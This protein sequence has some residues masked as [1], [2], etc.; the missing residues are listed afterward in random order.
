[1][2]TEI[3]F[4][5]EGRK[6][7]LKGINAI[8]DAVKVTLGAKGRNVIISK[9]YETLRITKD[10]VTVAKS[11]ELEDL[12]ENIGATLIKEVAGKTVDISGDGT[13]TATVLAQSIINAGVKAVESGANPMDLKRGIEKATGEVIKY[14]KSI[15]KTADDNATLKQIATVSANNDEEIG[16]LIADAFLKVGKDGIIKVQ[17]AKG[18]DT[19]IDIVEGM[20]IDRGYISHFFITNPEKQV[21][22]MDN[23]YILLYDGRVVMM[24][25]ILPILEQVAK[26]G[27]PLLIIAE[28]LE[29]EAL[30]TLVVNK[31]QGRLKICA[32]KSPEFGE[33][34]KLIMEDIAALTGATFVSEQLGIKLVQAT[35]SLLGSAD[36]V[37][38]D[39]DSC[40]IVGG[41]GIKENIE[42]RCN[43]IKNEIANAGNDYAKEKH[44]TRLA[45]LKD[46]IAVLSI[47]GVTETEIKEK[48]DRVDDALCAT[49][50]ASEEGYVA[51]GGVAYLSAI[52][53][54]KVN[55]ENEDEKIGTTILLKSLESPF[56]QILENGGVESS[57]Y[58]KEISNSEYGMG[59]N[60]KNNK[61]ENFFETGVIDPTKVLRVALEN[62]AS[63]ASIFLTTECIISD[64]K[65]QD[66]K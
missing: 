7:A 15:S 23:P 29:G 52:K 44:R 39:K 61:I 18:H 30:A 46:G 21:V 63:I 2:S 45:K 60:I 25:D 41:G 3:L 26:T 14:L 49:L 28:D 31:M 35:I 40:L 47:G 58:I 13:T 64:N 54:I 1:M 20:K 53:N 56:R 11:I 34:S 65:Q 55:P 22:E 38:I 24:N 42:V 16:K 19:T 59:Y 51:G 9:R 27:R 48:A 5:S 32:I 4:Y 33:N 10:G 36:V 17:Q 62:A 6:R 66:G 37:T 50:S 43:S 57:A 8:A 12:I